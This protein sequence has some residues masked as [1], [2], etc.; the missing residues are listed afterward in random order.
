MA[1]S[2]RGYTMAYYGD[3]LLT[4]PGAEDGTDGWSGSPSAVEGGTDGDYCFEVSEGAVMYQ[5]VTP[6]EGDFT[7]SVQVSATYLPEYAPDREAARNA[8]HTITV[9]LTHTSGQRTY[10]T[11]PCELAQEGA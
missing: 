9:R 4:N 1:L 7:G 6:A 11:C 2:F 10:H 5:S 3:N 8:Y